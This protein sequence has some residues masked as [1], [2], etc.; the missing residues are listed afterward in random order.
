MVGQT[1]NV[2]ALLDTIQ[3]C[4]KTPRVPIQRVDI[5]DV[6]RECACIIAVITVDRAQNTVMQRLCKSVQGYYGRIHLGGGNFRVE[7]K[8][9]NRFLSSLKHSVRVFAL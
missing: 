7:W 8:P 9:K 2:R 3:S 6:A 1:S 5:A 4:Q